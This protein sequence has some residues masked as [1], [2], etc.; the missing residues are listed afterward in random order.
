MVFAGSIFV[1]FFTSSMISVAKASPIQCDDDPGNYQ[2][3]QIYRPGD[4]TLTGEPSDMI[5]DWGGP[6]NADGPATYGA[7]NAGGPN[8][9]PPATTG[10]WWQQVMMFF[11]SLL[12][13]LGF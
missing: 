3:S 8:E 10:G 9:I 5:R 13:A 7:P 6:P 2:Q 1:L 11:A 12:E 4:E